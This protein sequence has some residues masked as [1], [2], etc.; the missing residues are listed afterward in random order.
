[1]RIFLKNAFYHNRRFLIIILLSLVTVFTYKDLPKTFFQQDEWLYMGTNII[2]LSSHNLFL[3]TVLP[4]QGG[5]THFF[6]LTTFYILLQYVLFKTD[7]QY[8]A[9][10]DIVFHLANGILVFFLIKKIT[11]SEI[12][13]VLTSLLFLTYSISHQAVSWVSAGSGILFATF[14]S[15]VALLFFVEYLGSKKIRYLLASLSSV[16]IA[17]LFKEI[18]IFI[19]L[20]MPLYW[21]YNKQKTTGKFI[22][23][24]KEVI[25]F[26]VLFGAYASLRLFFVFFNF[27]T[28]LFAV[29]DSSPAPKIVYL[30]RTI[31][32][33]LKG[34]SQSFFS[35]QFLI[36]TSEDIAR[37][38]YPQYSQFVYSTGEVNPY[39]SQTIMYD[40]L[41]YILSILLLIIAYIVFRVFVKEKAKTLKDGVVF[42]VLLLL[43]SLT[44]F[45]L[46]PGKVGYFS[47]FEPRHLYIASIGAS[48][49]IVLFLYVISGIIFKKKGQRV[50]FV[51]VLGF[52]LVSFH[53]QSIHKDIN[54]LKDI[55]ETR[56]S[57][58]T[59]VKTE[60]S[61]LPSQV[62]FYTE[63]DQVYYGIGDQKILPVQS[64]FGQML[65]VWYQNT[66]HFPICLYDREFL[67]EI[68]SEGYRFCDG[69]GF[70][71]FRNYKNLLAE[72]KKNNLKEDSIIGYSWNSKKEKFIDITFSLRAR[73]KRDLTHSTP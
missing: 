58:L 5:L 4:F 8:Y 53:I 51:C 70:G 18:S 15:L 12:F 13:S 36:K 10:A 6:P 38:S 62:V 69:R 14:F 72:F 66:E 1:M 48:L 31:A 67:Y 43:T 65:M 60:H 17:L 73:I 28:P 54:L 64:G 63:S 71:Y 40:F 44:P 45:I 7:F 20:F 3:N 35:Q 23:R 27:S 2:S 57:F 9:I 50:F 16:L 68:T 24:W 26:L 42:S 29:P 21:L 39:I 37:V 52:L 22:P 33:P 32:V 47:I 46:L 61:K 11:K 56:K 34:F 19:F 55:G 25:P 41:S 30:Y 49:A 59:K